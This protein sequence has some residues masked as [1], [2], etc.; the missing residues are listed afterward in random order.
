MRYSVAV[1]VGLLVICSAGRASAQYHLVEAMYWQFHGPVE[2]I[3]ERDYKFDYKADAIATEAEQS[4]IY[5]FDEDRQ[6]KTIE[7]TDPHGKTT[8]TLGYDDAGRLLTLRRE[9][10]VEGRRKFGEVRSCQRD[11]KGEITSMAIEE[12]VGIVSIKLQR[13]VENEAEGNRRMIKTFEPKDDGGHAERLYLIENERVLAMLKYDGF[14]DPERVS[15]ALR[16]DEKGNLQEYRSFSY[17]D[18]VKKAYDIERYK[19]EF[20]AHGNWT[21]QTRHTE[22]RDDPDKAMGR[23]TRTIKYRHE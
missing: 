6:L 12:F 17:I 5:R 7:E 8:F 16:Y 11:E 13:K 2:S 9:R 18:D 20:D 3:E 4:R 10:E 23:V 1:A 19:Y 15:R 22:F 21:S 14:S